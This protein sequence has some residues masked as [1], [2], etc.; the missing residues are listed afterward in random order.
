MECAKSLIA[1][2]A[3]AAIILPTTACGSDERLSGIIAVNPADYESAMY[4]GTYV[5]SYAAADATERVC[6][7]FGERDGRSAGISCSAQ[8][9]ADTPPVANGVF[10]GPPNTVTLTDAGVQIGIDEGG[11]ERPKL[12]PGHHHIS[13]G[14]FFCTAASPTGIS[15]AGPVAGFSIEDGRVT[16]SGTVLAPT[17]AR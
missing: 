11:P 15:C 17:P 16:Q 9:P 1:A 8:F 7:A 13:I 5:W 14:G 10:T 6:T 12:L 4:P 3:V 2:A